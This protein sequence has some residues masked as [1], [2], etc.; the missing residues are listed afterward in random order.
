V[1]IGVFHLLCGLF[2]CQFM[3]G[4]F[5]MYHLYGITCSCTGSALAVNLK[6]LYNGAFIR[7]C[8]EIAHNE[9]VKK[10]VL[11]SCIDYFDNV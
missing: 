1:S 7:Y 5:D 6:G 4:L 3:M 9:L 11:K 10:E 8:I 2:V